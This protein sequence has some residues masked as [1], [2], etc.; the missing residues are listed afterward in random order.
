MGFNAGG[1]NVGGVQAIE[2]GVLK[3]VVFEETSFAGGTEYF[4]QTVPVGKIWNVKFVSVLATG[5]T[6]SQVAYF[7][8]NSGGDAVTLAS[9]SS[10]SVSYTHSTDCQLSAG[11]IIKTQVTSSVDPASLKTRVIYQEIDA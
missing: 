4:D 1:T 7:I 6:V 9:A 10:P 5:G 2:G 11:D 8:Q 3:A